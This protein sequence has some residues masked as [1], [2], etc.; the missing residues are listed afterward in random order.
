MPS[1]QWPPAPD[2]RS[3][4]RCQRCHCRASHC[5]SAVAMQILS[6]VTDVTV[7]HL[8]EFATDRN[9]SHVARRLLCVIAGADVIPPQPNSSSMDASAIKA[10]KV[11]YVQLIYA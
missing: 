4:P 6:K 1:H 8:Y 10:G 5:Y 2:R 7:E 9:A 11:L 3:L